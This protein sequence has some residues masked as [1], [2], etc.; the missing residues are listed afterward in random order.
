MPSL[1]GLKYCAPLGEEKVRCFFVLFRLFFLSVTH[2][3]KKVCE[4]HFAM[5][6]LKF[7]ND[8]NIVG[9]GNV[10]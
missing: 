4:H 9:W 6:A 3:N 2:S 8:F 10:C 5:N 7:G 1:A